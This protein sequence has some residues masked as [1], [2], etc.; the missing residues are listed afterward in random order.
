MS[1]HLTTRQVAE[2]LGV[3]KRTVYRY[4]DKYG[5]VRQP[6]TD[7]GN[8]ATLWE[9]A[10][11]LASLGDDVSRPCPEPCPEPDPS[12][13]A[14]VP[15]PVTGRD[16]AAFLALVAALEQAGKAQRQSMRRL[17]G[18]VAASVVLILAAGGYAFTVWQDAEQ[19]RS[20]AQIRTEQTRIAAIEQ[21][22]LIMADAEMSRQVAAEK[23]AADLRAA[24]AEQVKQTKALQEEIRTLA[25]KIVNDLR[26]GA[27]FCTMVKM[28]SIKVNKYITIQYEIC[29]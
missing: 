7:Q 12:Q 19:S 2:M 18:I 5:W 29:Y 13:A 15:A 1:E 22:T 25:E 28:Y 21:Q 20:E 8:P 3:S 6:G 27:V 24:L 26:A 14:A 4:A 23:Q 16:N 10:A 9:K 17:A 11:I